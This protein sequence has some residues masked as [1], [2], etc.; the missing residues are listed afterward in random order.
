[1]LRSTLATLSALAALLVISGC[2]LERLEMED[3][4]VPVA[5][6]AAAS[7]STQGH[8]IFLMFE[9]EKQNATVSELPM[10]F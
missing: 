3:G 1:M 2:N 5:T 7:R 4:V 8:E 9:A 10:L 6:V